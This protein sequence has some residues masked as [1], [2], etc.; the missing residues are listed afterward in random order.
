MSP[1][2]HFSFHRYLAAKK[3]ID[4]RALNRGV[5]DALLQEV[6]ARPAATPLRVLEAG[7]GIGTMVERLMDWG[8]FDTW[9]PSAG[10]GAALLTAFDADPRNIAALRTRLPEWAA[11]RGMIAEGDREGITLSRAGLRLRVEA[12]AADL[13]SFAAR[14]RGRQT[15]DVLVANAVLDVLDVPAALDALL[16]LIPGGLLYAT[17][18]YD[19]LTAFEP[20]IDAALDERVIALYHRT[21]AE[22]GGGAG[23][24]GGSDAG[25][26]LF[27]Q[28]RVAECDVLAMGSADWVVF[29]GAGG[30]H[31]DDA[32]FLHF[33][34]KTIDEALRGRPE[35]DPLEYARW[36][37]TRRAQVERGE[38]VLIAHQLDVLARAPTPVGS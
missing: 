7:A 27:H 9:P 1:P 19:G 15:W 23:A 11:G 28:L 12:E 38:L 10:E 24:G 21:M 8:L 4:D 22:R 31:D 6:R 3:S 14:A 13:F 25:R 26:R 32:F 30:Y 37:T 33:I 20:V 16:P 36:I 29:P 2:R 18:T 35:L 5:W 34:L 17:I